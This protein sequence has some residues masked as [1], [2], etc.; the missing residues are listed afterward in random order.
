MKAVAALHPPRSQGQARSVPQLWHFAAEH[1]LALPLGAGFALIWANWDT[2]NYYR[3]VNATAMLVNDVAM[4]L[5][6]AL[7]TKEI[8]EATA[9]GGV[10]HPWRRAAMPVVAALGT[11]VITVMFFAVLVRIFGEPML[12]RGWTTALAIDIAV[13]YFVARLIFGRHAAIPFFLLLAISANGLGFV[14]LAIADPLHDVR[15]EIGGP[16]MLGAIAV[17]AGL[18]HLH[19]KRLWPYIVIGGG[20]SWSALYF[21]GFHPA[22]ALLPIV[23]FLPHA[24]RD[25]G[26]FVEASGNAHDALNRMELWFR[27][28]AQVALF[29]FGLVNAGVQFK[30]LESGVWSVPLAAVIGKPIG[31]LAGVA[32]GSAFGL[33][34]PHGLHRRD[35]IP[36]GFIAATGFTMT[37]FF[38]TATIG[39]GQLLSELK[40]GA[41]LT[42][43][44]C[45]LALATARMLKVGR[46]NSQGRRATGLNVRGA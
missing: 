42:L 41:I 31:L 46:F 26:F 35:L 5:F 22:L 39:A 25:P 3:L 20:L 37:L 38:A 23:P 14:A 32:I 29:F 18:R 8:V 2:E 27:H 19:V 4:V 15:L 34:L 17:A 7:I 13:G 12:A 1:L 45:L 24:A 36:L 10:L 33:H 9:P 43:S 40:M 21:G 28:P 30:A 16:L 6:F 11:A 44:G